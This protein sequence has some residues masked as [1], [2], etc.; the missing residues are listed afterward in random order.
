MLKPTILLLATLLSTTLAHPQ[1]PHLYPGFDRNEYP[2]D[3]TLPALRKTF[4]Y[5]GYWLNNPPGSHQ[6]SWTGKRAL[7]KQQGFGFLI[8]FN[9]RLDADLKKSDPAHLG[10]LDGQAASAAATRE[11]FP[12]NV[13]L[14]LDQE[15]GGRL[16]PEQA[17]YLFAWIDA[18]RSSGNRAGIYCSAIEVPDGP[19][20]ITTA[21]DIAAREQARNSTPSKANRPSATQPTLA[22]W[23]AND[24]CP[25]SPGCSQNAKPPSTALHSHTP[26]P[27]LVWQYAQSPRRSQF[28]A[29]CPKNQAADGNCYAPG[30]PH[31]P[32]TF[33]DLNI[34]TSPSPSETP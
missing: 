10:T 15:E 18:V 22:L 21:Q 24:Q 8:L 6:N 4:R 9:G 25:P 7:L 32:A 28:S 2:G 31:T 33:L 11:G 16:L 30:L 34:S 5:T 27:P 29:N 19:T 20:T 14:F 12:K 3:A 17:A 23:V 13:I 1:S 26:Q